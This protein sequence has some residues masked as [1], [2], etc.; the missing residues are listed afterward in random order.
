MRTRHL[1][2]V[3]AI[4]C[5]SCGSNCQSRKSAITVSAAVSL[6]DA[7][8][9][10][11][12]LYKERSGRD[13]T[14][15]FGSSGALQKQ[16]ETG[17]PVDVYAS[18]GKAQ[19]DALADKVLIDPATRNDFAHNRLVVIVP[20]DAQIKIESLNDLSGSEVRRIAAGNFNTVPAGQYFEEAL[21]KANTLEL[22]RSKLVFGED[23]R[24]VLDYVARGEVDAGLVYETDAKIAGG[25]V[26]IGFHV[27]EDLHDPIVYPIAKVKESKQPDAAREFIDLVR[28]SDGKAILSKFGFLTSG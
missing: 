8:T 24:Q 25:K 18:A 27:P 11:G 14:F 13:V 5:L 12:V 9:E 7:F 4:L 20:A 1:F 19:M 26:R 16:I 2:F 3:L 6:K 28:S 22:L 10:I 15:N 17:A 21:R 23:V